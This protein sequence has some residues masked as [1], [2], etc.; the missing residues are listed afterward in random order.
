MAFA[1]GRRE[2]LFMTTLSI[3]C[4]YLLIGLICAT[5]MLKGVDEAGTP[6]MRESRPHLAITMIAL[7]PA[8]M[9]IVMPLAI[10]GLW[11]RFKDGWRRGGPK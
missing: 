7:W 9:A 6:I 5:L 11:A 8:I 4:G 3:I 2:E 1:F 10:P